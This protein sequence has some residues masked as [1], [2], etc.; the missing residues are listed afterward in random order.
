MMVDGNVYYN[1]ALPFEGEANKVFLPDFNPNVKIEETA[2]GVYLSFSVKGLDGLQTSR[3]TTGRLG[4]AK[5]PRQAY[6]QPDGSSI[7]IATDYLGNARGSQPKPGPL[8]SVKE[9]EIKVKVW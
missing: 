6:E 9:G 5:L 4:K 3:V 7:E 8:E 2:D 1:G